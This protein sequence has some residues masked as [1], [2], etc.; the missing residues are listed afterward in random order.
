MRPCEANGVCREYIQTVFTCTKRRSESL[1]D[2]RL[3]VYEES[4][5]EEPSPLPSDVVLGYELESTNIVRKYIGVLDIVFSA[6]SRLCFINFS[7]GTVYR[8]MA[9]HASQFVWYRKLFVVFSRYSSINTLN[10]IE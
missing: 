3:D 5:A 2:V 8:A 1:S 9:A 7:P 6:S 4:E 10:L